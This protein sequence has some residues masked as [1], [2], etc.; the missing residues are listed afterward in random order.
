MR[1]PDSFCNLQAIQ[2]CAGDSAT[3]TKRN[4]SAPLRDDVAR[5]LWAQVVRSD[6]VL[7]AV[8]AAVPVTNGGASHSW[9]QV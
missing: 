4:A 7:A 9:K 8:P 6:A 3:S 2:L 1:P 5:L